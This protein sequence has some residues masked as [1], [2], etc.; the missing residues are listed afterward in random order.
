MKKLFCLCLASLHICGCASFTSQTAFRNNSFAPAGTEDFRFVVMGDNRPWVY[1]D[2]PIT[3]NEYF[4]GNIDRSNAAQA[5]FAVLAGD[6]ILGYINDTEI[7]RQEWIA[8][9]DACKKFQM[10]YVSV[11][12]NHDVWDKDSQRIWRQ[13]YGAQ[14]FSWNH[15]GCHFIALSSE[16]VGQSGRIT[17][18]Q[19]RW[20]KKDLEK[21]RSARR[22]F[23]FLHRPLWENPEKAEGEG[24]QWNRD[25]HPLLAQYEVDS[26]FAGHMHK[27]T[28]SPTRDNVRYVITGGAGAEL[29]PYEL[30][31]H[32]FHFLTVDVKGN[33]SSFKV[34]TPDETLPPDCVTA[35]KIEDLRNALSV[36]PLSRLPEDRRP[37][38]RLGIHNITD[39]EVTT[40]VTMGT[41]NPSWKIETRELIIP[42]GITKE[43][44]IELQVGTALLP[45]PTT[46]LEIVHGER[47]LFG[48][49]TF[50]PEAFS[51]LLRFVPE[52][53]IVGPFDLGL[54]DVTDEERVDTERYKTTTMSGWDSLLPPEERVKLDAVYEGKDHKK[55]H[56]RNI[57][58]EDNGY[59]NMDTFYEEI[60]YAV[61]CA[62]AYVHS[63][64]GGKYQASTGSDDSILVRVNGSEVWRYHAQRG[65]AP[66]QD[67]FEINLS[68]GWN[69]I[70][71]KVA[72]RWGGWGFYF[73]IVD[74]DNTLK[75]SSTNPSS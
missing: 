46:L 26:V 5:D 72:E 14:Y 54:V 25:V 24:N 11:V 6:L 57:K 67:I 73:R 60:D 41:N 65:A 43:L 34:V 27:Y 75:F 38:I 64:E 10:P 51:K 19:I 17:G 3:Q 32:F 16:I 8:Y 49:D 18:R 30:A 50:V 53:N 58:A 48:W 40:L 68:K 52:W 23:V 55:I 71:L 7:I 44:P 13:R 35:E 63:P 12:G 2:D 69:E 28:L 36:E 4:L 74:P 37:V 61:A 20:L 15:K 62:V 33:S 1:A 47:K 31:G 56:W 45:L 39:K 66:D 21:A 59:V 22:I 9:A 70:L 42:P 29:D